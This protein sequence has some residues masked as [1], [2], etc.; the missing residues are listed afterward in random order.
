[1][2]SAHRGLPTSRLFTDLDKVRK[3][4][5]FYITVLNRTLAYE[6]DRIS[7]VK[8]DQT[9]ELS[10][11]PGKDLVT[12]VT[13]TPYG[14]NTQR[15]LVRGHRVPYNA[16]QAKHEA[17]DSAVSSFTVY[18]FVAT[19]GTLAI[20]LAGIA[21]LRRNAAARTR[22]TP[23][24]GRIASP[25][26]SANK[27]RLASL[28][29]SVI[30]LPYFVPRKSVPGNKMRKGNDRR[31]PLLLTTYDFAYL[32]RDVRQKRR[33]NRRFIPPTMLCGTLFRSRLCQTGL[34]RKS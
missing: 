21:V 31:Y 15:L 17:A 25:S 27:R 33:K 5:H 23:P 32:W 4:D 3:G 6:V 19:Y 8:P 14:V 13:C 28:T 34:N 30:A 29:G 20:V 18:G 12:L 10:V 26:Q 22:I 11:Q 7:V 2:L 24:I 1:M 16:A 9:K